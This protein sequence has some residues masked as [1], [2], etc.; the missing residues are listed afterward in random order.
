[1]LENT[2][3]KGEI[4]EELDLKELFNIFWSRRVYIAIITAIFFMIGVIYT[5][6]F[7]TPDYESTTTV[8][9]AQSTS[10][11]TETGEAG[12]ITTTDLTLNQKLVSTYSELIKSKNILSEV[13][14]NLQIDKTE[15]NLKNHI[16][17]SAVKDTDLIKIKVTDENPKTAKTI[18]AEVANVFIDK[19]ANGVYHI[20][21]VQ[22][23]DKAEVP[24]S[25]YNINHAKDLSLFIFIGIVVSAVYALVANM[26]DTTVKSQEDIEK[27]IGLSVLTTIPI[28]DFDYTLE[29]LKGGRK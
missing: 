28:C 19:V 7:V 21:N 27:K 20:N 4:M 23:W 11:T 1:M 10:K 12:T 15:A 2:K 22:V 16:S 14:N 18:A 25:P 26:L 13:I 29:K 24:T 9:L 8:I 5:F 6:I 3:K 17:V